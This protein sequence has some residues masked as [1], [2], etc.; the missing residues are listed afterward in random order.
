MGI[1]SCGLGD[2]PLGYGVPGISS[3]WN[4]S[5]TRTVQS[6]LGRGRLRPS[7][8]FSLR[9]SDRR[10]LARRNSPGP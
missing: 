4:F 2:G 10:C 5:R 1:L 8:L 9:R 3:G 7:R 6:G